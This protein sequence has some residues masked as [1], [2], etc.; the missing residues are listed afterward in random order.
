MET[1]KDAV[2]EVLIESD[3]LQARIAELGAEISRE[4]EG[5][6]LLL[7]GVLKGRRLLHG[8]PDARADR[9]L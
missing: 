3:A 8:R 9:P 2:G 1:V 6:D 5:R 7:V 4:Y